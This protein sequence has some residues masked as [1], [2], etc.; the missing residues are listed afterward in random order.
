VND[1]LANVLAKTS[2]PVV[3]DWNK[4][5]ID[6]ITQLV[7]AGDPKGSPYAPDMS[8]SPTALFGVTGYELW[9]HMPDL[10]FA[11]SVEASQK[12][13]PGIITSFSK[14][15]AT[16][17]GNW[18]DATN[19]TDQ[20]FQRKADLYGILYEIYDQL[21]IYGSGKIGIATDGNAAGFKG[22]S[23]L[24]L[25]FRA[26]ALSKAV[27]SKGVSL[28]PGVLAPSSPIFGPNKPLLLP[29]KLP[30]PSIKTLLKSQVDTVS[31]P[32]IGAG[33]ALSKFSL[34]SVTLLEVPSGMPSRSAFGR[35][36]ISLPIQISTPVAWVPVTTYFAAKR[37]EIAP[38]LVI[39][40]VTMM[41]GNAS[42]S[43]E[44]ES[45]LRASFA[46]TH[47]VGVVEYEYR[48]EPISTS[49]G[50]GP[51]SLYKSF[52]NTGA[53]SVLPTGVV[54]SLVNKTST[55]TSVS[56]AVSV[57]S[58]KFSSAPAVKMGG[59]VSAVSSSLGLAG[60]KGAA[61]IA[62]GSA[63]KAFIL[64]TT[65]WLSVGG[66]HDI[67]FLFI[68]Q[69]QDPGAYAL[70]V[71]FRGA[72]GRTITRQGRFTVGYAVPGGKIPVTSGMDTSDN[73]PPTTP[74]VTLSG[75]ATANK[76]V[77]YAKWSAND[78]SSGIQGYQYAVEEYTDATAKEATGAVQGAPPSGPTLV[79]KVLSAHSATKTTVQFFASGPLVSASEAASHKWIDAQGRTEANIRGLSL[80][81]A[82]R[83]VV[84]VMATNGVGRASIGRSEPIVV[85]AVP[86]SAP[87]ITA[88]QQLSADGY[89]NSLSFT[90]T[91]GADSVSGISGHSFA[92]GFT[93]KDE[94]L[95]PWTVAKG[96]SA[97]IVNLPMSKGQQ[98]VL[99][100]DAV[101]G[102]G[103]A[104]TATKT[105]AVAYGAGTPPVPPSVVSDPLHFTSNTSQL[106]LSWSPASDP[107]S[108]IVAYE[109]GVGTSPAKVDAL[110]WTPAAASFTPYVLGQGP[111][112]G[113]S[114][115]D[116]KAK[117]A[118]SLA[119]KGTYYA[120]VRATNGNGLT[121]VGASLPVVV[122]LQPPAVA[123]IVPSE[124]PG[125]DS[126][127]VDVSA[128]DAIS[129]L[130]R[131]RAKVWE[132]KSSSS[133]RVD[134]QP[135]AVL[136][137][138]WAS[139]GTFTST[140]QSRAQMFA[141]PQ[142][143]GSPWMTT[144]WQ[145]IGAGAPPAQADIQ[146]V[147][148]GFPGKGLVIGKSYRVAVEVENGAGVSAQ[149]KQ[150]AVT[151]VAAK[152]SYKFVPKYKSLKK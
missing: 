91:P 151:V 1:A 5:R 117:A 34:S 10:G 23:A 38:Y 122:D 111:Q 101:S 55:F 125:S 92:V 33:K 3:S 54:S 86:P 109:Y 94:K 11:A 72:G 141:L 40:Q 60:G 131:Y 2:G 108:G 30:G 8:V 82:K 49:S 45:L 80:E 128:K 104:T 62:M 77:L 76:E 36:V 64:S 52:F 73:T 58:S 70:Y 98:V 41:N 126:I 75:A 4:K 12:S 120:L 136:V 97:T 107:D 150:F 66:S 118:V 32:I 37:A 130:A 81:Q 59:K 63:L 83:Y 78:P 29:K 69:M 116:M 24:G 143:E 135:L 53:K 84:W 27:S 149:S 15:S 134:A 138:G 140:A 56:P 145:K 123:L 14:S 57:V 115:P 43:S 105:L 93:D 50:L 25:S 46:G 26:S 44:L 85:D 18:G 103:L 88:F 7:T 21:A 68:P 124:S 79:N 121:S 90:F 42:S 13:M 39:P 99:K 102:A 112:G 148:T 133:E 17:L 71:K 47:P 114:Q 137:M 67:N 61:V 144:Q 129:G 113:Q 16:L 9:F 31:L 65:P 89:A 96:T 119:D 139:Q 48:I 35:S 19:L 146:I 22:I 95:W 106:A 110:S 147:I 152:P 28:P 132:A 74:V 87:E 127:V 6:L 100:V 142:E 51:E 20:V